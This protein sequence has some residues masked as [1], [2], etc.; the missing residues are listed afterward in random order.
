LYLDQSCTLI[1]DG[2]GNCRKLLVMG[3][4]GANNEKNSVV[5]NIKL[6][7][8]VTR[9]IDVAIS[10]YYNMDVL[11]CPYRYY[12]RISTVLTNILKP[13]FNMK[14][15]DPKRDLKCGHTNFRRRSWETTK[16][17]LFVTNSNRII[18][19][20]FINEYWLFCK[21]LK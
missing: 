3:Y 19:S 7:W 16:Y 15:T 21:I 20:Q 4:L 8:N 17:S 12:F 6:F 2:D 10:F 1:M 18:I 14:M 11:F 9:T 5:T 13:T